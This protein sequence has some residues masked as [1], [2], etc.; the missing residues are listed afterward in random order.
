MYSVYM[1]V[2][3]YKIPMCVC[4]CDI[5]VYRNVKYVPRML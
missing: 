1:Y 2:D 4:V 3:N 5:Y